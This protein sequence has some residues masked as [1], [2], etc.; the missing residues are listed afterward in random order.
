MNDDT[1]DQTGFDVE[2]T[3][4]AGFWI[5]VA[6]Y[7]ID[8]L[9]LMVFAISALFMK[10]VPLYILLTIPLIAYKPVL[11]GLLGGTAGKLAIGL[12]VISHEGRL[13]GLAGGFVRSGIF[14]LPVIPNMLLQI[15]MI[16]LGVSPFDP[17]AA[18]AF[19]ENNELLYLA[20]YG[21]SILTVISCI[22]VAFTQRKR[23]LHDMIADSYVI[24][25]DKGGA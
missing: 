3:R 20:Y 24:H 8:F 2:R 11:E 12:R 22:V 6:A 5:R 9:I 1:L 23:G 18:M 16:Q 21:L 15:K 7:L 14:I 10:S 19:Q 17:Q 4:P 25:L 13:L